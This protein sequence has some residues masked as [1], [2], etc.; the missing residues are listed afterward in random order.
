MSK[1]VRALASVLAA[2][3]AAAA[4]AV[5]AAPAQATTSSPVYLYTASS[6]AGCAT[7][8][9]NGVAGRVFARFSCQSGFAGYSLSVE[10]TRGHTG[11]ASV[12]LATLPLTTCSSAGRNGVAGGV[13]T[14]FY[15]QN[16]FAGYSL[17]VKD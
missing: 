2:T 14:T 11:G 17:M 6:L 16:G 8:G 9:N 7:T 3:A 1:R 15:C 13:F 12:Y 5:S 4:A 10:P